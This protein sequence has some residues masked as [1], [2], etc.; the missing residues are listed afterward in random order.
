M[1]DSAPDPHQLNARL[2][3]AARDL[4]HEVDTQHTLQR[5]VALATEIVPGCDYA[6]VSVVHR[7]RPINTPALTDDLVARVDQL[8]YE[9]QEGPCL[10]SIWTHET[11]HSRDLRREDRWPRWAPRVAEMGIGSIVCLQLYTSEDTLG[12]LNLL[13]RSV[14][15]YQ[16]EDII[17]AS[18]LAAHVS[19]ALAEAQHATDL[20]SAALDRTVIGRAEGILMERFRL[21]ANHAFDMLT[22]VAG[23]SGS[24]VHQVA[25]L[26]VQGGGGHPS[27]PAGED[28]GVG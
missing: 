23:E 8:Q 13:S 17:T 3:Q 15:A 12:A 4:Q 5:A 9:V 26:V 18:Y 24:R 14:D 22:R 28:G 27:A 10:E 7:R 1:D 2:A 25:T 11:V 20:H 6:G 19:V 16:E 21:S